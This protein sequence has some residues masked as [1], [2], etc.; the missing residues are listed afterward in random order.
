MNPFQEYLAQQ[1]TQKLRDRRVVVWYDEKGEFAPFIKQLR[2]SG[3]AGNG[4]I[5]TVP[6]Q[7]VETNLVE[8]DGSFWAVRATVEPLVKVDAPDPLLIYIPGEK[9][10]R[11]QSLLMELELAGECYQPQLPQL[12]RF[13]LREFYTDGDIDDMLETD[14]LTYEDVVAFA[15]Q[16]AETE[17]P[18]IL[19]VI[20]EGAKDSEGMLTAWLADPDS[21]GDIRAKGATGELFRLLEGRLGLKM[22]ED[23]NI[24][25]ARSRCARYVLVNHFRSDFRG[26]DPEAFGMIPAAS[27]QEQ[28]RRIEKVVTGLRSDFKSAYADMATR[29]ESELGLSPDVVQAAELGTENTFPFEE[30]ALLKWCDQCIAEGNL[31]EVRDVVERQTRSFWVS[32]DVQRQMQWE[33]VRLMAELAAEIRRVEDEMSGSR[34]PPD[35]WID[36]YTDGDGGWCEVD[37][38]HRMLEG[39]I[40]TMDEECEAQQALVHVRDIQER[41]LQQMATNFTESLQEA[42]WNVGSILPQTRIYQDMVEGKHQRTAYF[43]VDALR[44]EMGV[45]LA[46]RLSDVEGLSVRPA[47]ASLPSVTTVGMAALLPEASTS[48]S[49]VEQK[50][51]LGVRLKDAMLSTRKDRIKYLKAREP[52][53]AELKLDAVLQK[54]PSRLKRKM[55]GASVV[56]VHSQEI[57]ALAEM[58]SELLARQVMD[59]VVGNVARAVRKLADLGIERFVITAD[60]GY[61]FARRKGEH[62]R[63][64]NPGGDIVKLARRCWAGRGG[65]T[66]TGAV[67]VSGVELG[68]DSDLDFIF[69]TGLGVFRTQ[70]G[71]SYH[72]GGCSLQEMVVPVIAFQIP[73]K[74]ETREETPVTLTECPERITNRTF[75]VQMSIGTNLF[76]GESVSLRV[77]LASDGEQVGEAGMAINAEYDRSTGCV[78]VEPG[79]QQATVTLMLTR[80]E[81]DDLRVM[82]L[83]PDSDAVLAQS[84]EIPVELGI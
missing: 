36:A 75:S 8:Y 16:G 37:L 49:V 34:R 42:D 53:S 81:C 46:R 9:R 29:V 2:E 79:M 77:I 70:G 51:D 38:L 52:D 30:Q 19:K 62:M 60:H 15:K 44:Y 11:E 67:R 61:Q 45:M 27:L 18:S 7:D 74:R 41:I 82:I 10:D 68:Y 12:A 5:T 57:D 13:A 1:L 6:I 35:W 66:P 69:P 40:A 59:T 21:D 64:D 55:N 72:H 76:A 54:P 25:D 56:M 22:D 65:S 23:D 47:A 20:F 48:F 83:D 39:Q 71:L 24:A 4:E 31:E 14:N 3:E 32:N 58:G 43:A 50:G 78:E 26:D 28:S 80:E 63:T 73:E 33:C 17:K 84:D